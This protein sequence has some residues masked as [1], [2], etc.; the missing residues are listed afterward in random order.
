MNPK[1]KAMLDAINAKKQEV[2]NLVTEN[3]IE[4]ATAAKNELIDLQA[5]FDLVY[6]LEDAETKIELE[7]IK[8]G[9]AIVISDKT[10]EN[11]FADAARTGFK[12]AYTG[13]SE[14]VAA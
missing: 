3:K 9:N 5:K 7:N 14:G 6:D 10:G 1:L 8:E 13:G 11:K 4:E 12:N 2:K